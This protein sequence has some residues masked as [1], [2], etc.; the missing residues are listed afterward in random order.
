MKNNTHELSDEL[1]VG[2][3]KHEGIEYE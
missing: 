1:P 2:W 3:E